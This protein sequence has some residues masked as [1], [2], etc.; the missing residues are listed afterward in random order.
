MGGAG[1]M[2]RWYG[3]R[4]RLVSGDFMHPLPQ[5]ADKVAELLATALLE[6]YGKYQ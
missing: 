1:T 2:A 3:M 5:G 6:A 4:P